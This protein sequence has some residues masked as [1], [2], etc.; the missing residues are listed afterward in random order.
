MRE[1]CLDALDERT[2]RNKRYPQTTSSDSL[3]PE[4]LILARTSLKIM[5]GEMPYEEKK[6]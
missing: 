5:S 6:N 3:Q 2:A 4:S 1:R